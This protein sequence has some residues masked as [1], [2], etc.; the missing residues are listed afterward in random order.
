MRVTRAQMGMAVTANRRV[1]EVGNADAEEEM[2]MQR[3]VE[4]EALRRLSSRPR[5]VGTLRGGR[6]AREVQRQVEEAWA[7]GV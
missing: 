6:E 1:A 4:T 2:Q 3:R 7:W 5:G